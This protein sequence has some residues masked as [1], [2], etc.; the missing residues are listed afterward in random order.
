MIKKTSILIAESDTDLASLLAS[1]LTQQGCD[2][3]IASNGVIAKKKLLSHH[4]DFLITDVVMPELDG[5]QLLA[6]LK[7]REIT[8]SVIVS[9]GIDFDLLPLP[10]E[11]N[12]IMKL[13]KPY[14]QERLLD[15]TAILK[16][17]SHKK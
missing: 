14:N 2:V 8:I 1:Y 6:W 12:I 17:S 4:F 10:N 16:S 9:S 7:Q 5:L 15:L 13:P 11:D 3:F